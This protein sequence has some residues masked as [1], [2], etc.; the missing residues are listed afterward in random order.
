MQIV[1]KITPRKIQPNCVWLWLYVFMIMLVHLFKLHF[2]P[3]FS[4][5]DEVVEEHLEVRTPR[6]TQQK[7]GKS[8]KGRSY[9]GRKVG[10]GR[11]NPARSYHHESAKYSEVS[12]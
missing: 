5:A 6:R 7:R 2:Y 8:K 3:M 9:G 10:K 1:L 12:R 4:A 11:G